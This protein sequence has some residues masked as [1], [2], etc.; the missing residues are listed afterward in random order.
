MSLTTTEI[1]K[2][3]KKRVSEKQPEQLQANYYFTS[4]REIP[5]VNDSG[6]GQWCGPI[7][8]F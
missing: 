4:E 8:R 5:L 3:I 1:G 2:L 7:F 6:A